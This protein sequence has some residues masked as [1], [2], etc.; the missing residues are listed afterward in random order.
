MVIM[1][2]IGYMDDIAIIG[3]T[4]TSSLKS[5]NIYLVIFSQGYREV[6]VFFGLEKH[7]KQALLF[8]NNN[9]SWTFWK[10]LAY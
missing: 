5:N 2:N 10:R 8:Q 7:S 9:M 4:R 1:I 3:T 6:E